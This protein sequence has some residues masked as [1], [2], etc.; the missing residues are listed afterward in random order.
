V[1]LFPVRNQPALRRAASWRSLPCLS[2]IPKC[3]ILLISGGTS[4]PFR[5]SACGK[6]LVNLLRA[7]T[8]VDSKDDTKPLEDER[9]QLLKLRHDSGKAYNVFVPEEQ[10][11]PHNWDRPLP[12]PDDQGTL[13]PQAVKHWRYFEKTRD[14]LRQRYSGHRILLGPPLTFDCLV[15]KFQKPWTSPRLCH[16]S[17]YPFWPL[18]APGA[19]NLS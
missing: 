8:S 15:P 7:S 3:G 19:D 13:D 16:F 11:H 1:Q 4:S 5:S 9:G 17:A 18:I 2:G 14:F 12:A 6:I 10:P